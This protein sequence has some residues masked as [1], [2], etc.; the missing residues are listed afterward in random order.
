MLLKNL[1]L[2]K[3]KIDIPHG[4]RAGP[5]LK[6]YQKADVDAVWA[7]ST[8]AKKIAAKKT[9]AGLTDFDRFRVK[10]LKQRKARIIKKASK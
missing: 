2:T 4:A 7:A 5:V 6:A 3:I 10:V 9:R 1:N 8:W